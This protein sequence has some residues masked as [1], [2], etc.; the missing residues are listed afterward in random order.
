MIEQMATFLSIKPIS[1]KA[2]Q[3]FFFTKAF[4][5]FI[6]FL[7]VLIHDL[8]YSWCNKLTNTSAVAHF[9]FGALPCCFLA[10]IILVIISGIIKLMMHSSIMFTFL[11]SI[12]LSAFLVYLKTFLNDRYLYHLIPLFG[13]MVL[14]LLISLILFRVKKHPLLVIYLSLSLG[15][16]VFNV[17]F[18]TISK[19]ISYNSLNSINCV[20]VLIVYLYLM[21]IFAYLNKKN[22]GKTEE[23][24]IIFA[25]KSYHWF[26]FPIP[27]VLGILLFGVA[28][29]IFLIILGLWF[30]FYI[31]FKNIHVRAYIEPEPTKVVLIPI[32]S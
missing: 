7:I 16:M 9:I 25:C 28:F 8:G 24:M 31:C 23:E 3:Y 26:L 5:F 29:L 27:P 21:V 13:T 30:F 10:I 19:S 20:F 11:T 12:L 2:Y 18:S 14:F 32:Y 17:I 4:Q 22:E 1:S 6:L 15:I